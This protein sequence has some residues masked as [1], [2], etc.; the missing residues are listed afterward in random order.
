M[1]CLAPPT[2]VQKLGTDG[3]ASMEQGDERHTYCCSENWFASFLSK[4]TQLAGCSICPWHIH[5]SFDH[6]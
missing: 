3:D 5:E 1:P 6:C 2:C 4:E